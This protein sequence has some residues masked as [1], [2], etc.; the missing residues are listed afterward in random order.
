VPKGGR[1]AHNWGSVDNP[2]DSTPAEND[3]PEADVAAD[4]GAGD[5]GAPEAEEDNTK[6]FDDYL[7][8]MQ[9]KVPEDDKKLQVRQAVVDDKQFK[10]GTVLQVKEDEA[11]FADVAV[12]KDK[13][14]KAKDKS[15]KSVSLDEFVATVKPG[16]GNESFEE[17][18]RENE[19]AGFGSSGGFRGRGGRGGGRGRGGFRGSSDAP[20]GG[21][22]FRGSRGG[23][24]GGA[25]GGDFRGGRG[26]GRG[27]F[28]G[29]SEFRGGRGGAP[30]AAPRGGAGRAVDMSEEAF[31]SL[32]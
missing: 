30:G 28:R 8:Q 1:G 10:K 25:G 27:G 17:R 19:A 16:A 9:A 20:R 22:S 23:A 29:N 5:A 2:V 12:S 4:A 15:K 13:K 11:L 6:T 24:R 21:G 14:Q 32:K 31:P 7:A 18:E 3:K 26:G